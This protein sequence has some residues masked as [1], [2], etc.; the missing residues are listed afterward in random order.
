[1]V[2]GHTIGDSASRVLVLP[3]LRAASTLIKGTAD[4]LS[5]HTHDFRD[6]KAATSSLLSSWDTNYTS[7]T[8]SAHPSVPAA[9]VCPRLCCIQ[10]PV[11]GTGLVLTCHSQH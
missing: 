3:G 10:A 8:L 5:F 7:H 4:L 2:R 6:L 1:M 11:P 9:S